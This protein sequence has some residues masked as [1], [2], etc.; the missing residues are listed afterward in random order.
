MLA[1]MGVGIGELFVF[2]LVVLVLFGHRLPETMRS[3]GK[4]ITE[5]KKGAAE[6]EANS[7]DAAGRKQ[8]PNH[9]D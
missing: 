3:L 6:E 9:P 8:D 7:D 2:S 4:S 5:F 1:F